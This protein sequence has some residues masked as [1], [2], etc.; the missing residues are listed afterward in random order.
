MTAARG[1]PTWGKRRYAQLWRQRAEVSG[2][3]TF[4]ALGDSAA[5]GLGAA[6]PELGYVGLLAAAARQRSG[7]SVRVLNLG[8]SG[9]K[10]RDVLD[11]QVPLLA[12]AGGDVVTCAVGGNDMRT[13]DAA[14]FERDLRGIV[15]ALPRHALIADVP[16]FYGG[17]LEERARQAAAIARRVIED[18]G[19]VRIDLHAATEART[20]DQ[21]RGDF[22]LDMFHPN[23]RGYT[24]WAAAFEPAFLARVDE[25]A[26]ALE[27]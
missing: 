13:F 21:V 16:C 12:A 26:A 19:R 9:A 15:E 18:A 14:G 4:V 7:R 27:R 11:A 23:N 10:V 24:V 22:A 8:V 5:L 25:V 6:A 17:R 20:R 3:M 2:D 1:L